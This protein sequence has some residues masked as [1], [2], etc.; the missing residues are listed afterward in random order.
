MLVIYW[1]SMR[2][3]FCVS[4]GL[5]KDINDDG[6]RPIQFDWHG[7]GIFPFSAPARIRRYIIVCVIYHRVA[8][9]AGLIVHTVVEHDCSMHYS[10][11]SHVSI[12]IDEYS[13]ALIT[14]KSCTNR[15]W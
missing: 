3:A 12:D 4:R 1:K 5:V 15:I 7:F 14:H 10:S 11:I 13:F 2:T 8:A 6:A 9:H